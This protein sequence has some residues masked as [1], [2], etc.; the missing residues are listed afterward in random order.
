ME[1]TVLLS[2]HGDHEIIAVHFLSGRLGTL[3]WH[4]VDES[5]PI[6]FL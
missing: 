2:G 3:V 6:L 1:V 4:R 5:S